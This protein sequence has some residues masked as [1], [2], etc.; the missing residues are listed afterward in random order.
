MHWLA[1]VFA[2]AI[3]RRVAYVLVAIILGWCGI[4]RAEAK[5]YPTQGAAYAGCMSSTQAYLAARNTPKSDSNPRCV[6]LATGNK[7]YQGMFS[8]KPCDTCT[9]YDVEVDRHSWLAGC[10]AEPSYTGAGPWGSYIGTARSGSI[11]CRNGCDGVWF[12]NADE[13]MTWQTTGA[14]CPEDPPKTCEGMKGYV[15]NRYLG[16]CEPTPP[17]KCPEGQSKNAKG[18]CEPNACPDGMVLGADGTCKPKDNECPAGQIKSPMGSCIPG[19]GQCAAGEV[20]GKDGTCKRDGDGDGEPDAGEDDGSAQ[21]NFSG[22][23]DC[24]SPP[25]CSGDLIMCGQARIQWR[26]DCNTRKNRNISGGTCA[27]MPVCTGEKCDAMEYSSLL[28]QWR[29]ACALERQ[30]AGEGGAGETGIK[31]HMTAMKQAEVNAL[32]GLGT[33]DGHAGVDPNGIW[34]KDADY[35]QGKITE[36]L[37]GSGGGSCDLSFTIGGRLVTPPPQFWRICSIIHWLMVAAAYLWVAFKMGG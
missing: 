1:R 31:D 6:I 17:D 13:T 22:G 19:D 27:A 20:R 35:G 7:F 12:G 4:G 3:A 25:S 28:M 10:D 15:W 36:T 24:N 11:G 18:T 9:P 29:T 8:F 37:F 2:S 33:D 21:Q 30:K 16:V 14:V 5:E 26:I 23:D 32:R 34:A